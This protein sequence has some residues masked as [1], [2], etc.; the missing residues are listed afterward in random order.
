M[1]K[2]ILLTVFLFSVFLPFTCQAL[3]EAGDST[4]DLLQQVAVNSGYNIEVNQNTLTMT[5][6]SFLLIF[7]TLLGVIFLLIT[8][9]SGFRWMTAGGNEEQITEAKNLLKNAVI[10]LAIIILSYSITYFVTAALT[11]AAAG[12][13]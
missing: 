5:V 6:A 3:G 7:F 12:Q 4:A 8:V 1:F 10:G 11:F 9:Y 13:G 2:K